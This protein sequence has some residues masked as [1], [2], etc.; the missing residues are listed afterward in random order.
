M[1]DDDCFDATEAQRLRDLQSANIAAN[2]A[3]VERDGPWLMHLS[4]LDD[5]AACGAAPDAEGVLLVTRSRP[6][7]T[8]AACKRGNDD[9]ERA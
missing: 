5:G 6:C 4:T 2:Y 3:R 9:D 8:C 7:V 1:D